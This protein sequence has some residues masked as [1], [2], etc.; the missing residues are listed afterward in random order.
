MP[1]QPFSTHNVPAPPHKQEAATKFAFLR[2]PH[3]AGQ[4]AFITLPAFLQGTASARA[5]TNTFFCFQSRLVCSICNNSINCTETDARKLHIRVLQNGVV[6][7]QAETKN[8]H[9]RLDFPDAT[10]L[11]R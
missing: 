4:A 1:E 3:R 10:M 11:S 5:K 7:S 6:L 9:T 2:Q 8:W